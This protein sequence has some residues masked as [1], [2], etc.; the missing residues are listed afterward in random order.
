[1]ALAAVSQRAVGGRFVILRSNAGGIGHG[2]G[3]GRYRSAPEIHESLK[4]VVEH[5]QREREP[6][7]VINRVILLW[8]SAKLSGLLTRAQQKSIVEEALGK[9]Q[10]DGGF[11]LPAFVGG[12]IRAR[13]VIA[14]RS[15]LVL[16]V[17]LSCTPRPRGVPSPPSSGHGAAGPGL[18]RDFMNDNHAGRSSSATR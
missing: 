9:Q 14:R 6:Q 13:P 18:H 7:V 4:L 1:M 17:Y 5:L 2:L 10:A 8:A 3:A 11:S 16:A 12:W 15:A